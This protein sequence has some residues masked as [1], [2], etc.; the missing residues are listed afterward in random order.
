MKTVF[1]FNK[2][3]FQL[4]SSH[5]LERGAPH[6]NGRIVMADEANPNESIPDDIVAIHSTRGKSWTE[7]Q[8]LEALANAKAS[9][10]WL[11]TADDFSSPLTMT[12]YR[13]ELGPPQHG[14]PGGYRFQPKVF[15]P[16]GNRSLDSLVQTMAGTPKAMWAIRP[17]TKSWPEQKGP[18][19][20]IFTRVKDEAEALFGFGQQDALDIDLVENGLVVG[21]QF[22]N[23]G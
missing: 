2:Q 23:L 1:D 14:G 21:D 8:R 9:D 5:L 18:E 11:L 12:R 20:L 15:K 22:L 13:V 19:L 16:I 6:G 7:D 17:M 4:R 3:G 10:D